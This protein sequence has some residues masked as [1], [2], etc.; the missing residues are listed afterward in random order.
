MVFTSLKK[1]VGP[2]RASRAGGPSRAGEREPEPGGRPGERLDLVSGGEPS[3]VHSIFSS[4]AWMN[5]TAFGSG[6]WMY[7]TVKFANDWPAASIC[8]KV[9]SMRSAG[10]L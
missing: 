3:A 2:E 4:G 9:A 10:I 8:F 6:T 7:F 5:F 1:N